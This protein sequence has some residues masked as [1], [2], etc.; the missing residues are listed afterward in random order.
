MQTKQWQG[1]VA[2]MPEGKELSLWHASVAHYLLLLR[3]NKQTN[4]THTGSQAI[5]TRSVY[6]PHC[7]QVGVRISKRSRRARSIALCLH[8]IMHSPRSAPFPPSA[9]SKKKSLRLFA[10]PHSTA[11]YICIPHENTHAHTHG[12]VRVYARWRG[13]VCECVIHTTTTCDNDDDGDL[14]L[15]VVPISRS[16]SLARFLFPLFF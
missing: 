2:A 6:Q 14:S 1:T 13:R 15:V 9:S 10:A 3:T 8:F 4:P 11:I 5:S 16:R 7:T 12:H